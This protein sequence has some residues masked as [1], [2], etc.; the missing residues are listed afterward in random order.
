MLAIFE[1]AYG[2]DPKTAASLNNLGTVLQAQGRFADAEPVLRR[3][4]AIKEKTLGP[5]SPSTAHTLNN[6]AQVL[7]ELGRKSEAERYAARAAAIHQ[8]KG[9][10]RK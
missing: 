3:S 10:A 6:L 2:D 1:K 8:G 4:L 9:A 5:D 7:V